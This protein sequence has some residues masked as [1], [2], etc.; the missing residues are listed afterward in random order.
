[1]TPM[2]RLPGDPPSLAKEKAEALVKA[3]LAR[4]VQYECPW[5]SGKKFKKC[6]GA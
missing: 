3:E 4:R 1:M 5:G 2:E 6:C